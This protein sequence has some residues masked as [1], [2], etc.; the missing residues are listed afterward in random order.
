MKTRKSNWTAPIIGILFLLIL[1]TGC[2][3][4]NEETLAPEIPVYA[5]SFDLSDIQLRE[6]PFLEARETN[7]GYLLSLEPDRFLA[8]FRKEAGLEPKGEVYGG[9]ESEGYVIAG[10]SLGHYLSALSKQYHATGDERFKERVDYIVK[11][12]ALVQEEHGDGYVAAIRDG[13][14]AFKEI[15]EGNI[16][17]DGFSLNEVNVPWY[18]LDKTFNGLRDAF[19]LAENEQALEVVT[20]LTTWAYNITEDLTE[21]EWQEMLS[22]EFGGMIHSLANVYAIT[23]NPRHLKLAEKFYHHEVLDP[24]SNGKDELEGLHA[25][26]QIPKV[27]GVA[28]IHELTDKQ[29]YHTIA[30][31]FWNQVVSSHTYVNGGHGHEEAFGPPN[32]LSERLNH[33]TETC[34]TYNMLWLTRMLFSWNPDGELMDYYE[35]AL[36]NHIL[37]S[38]NPETG[39]FVYKG[40][41]DMPTRKG[42]SDSTNSF[43]CCVGTGMEN[44]THY[45]RD[46]Y[47][48]SG[49][50]LYVNLFMA[51]DLEWE[52]Q[53]LVLKQETDFPVEEGSQ[54]TLSTD[55]PVE[56]SLLIREPNWWGEDMEFTVNGDR[57]QLTEPEDGYHEIRRT[58][59]DGDVIEI[60][61]PMEHRIEAMPDDEK[62][63]AF[64]YGPVLL[65]AILEEEPADDGE[66]GE[67]EEENTKVPQLKGSKEELLNA[68]EP[69]EGKELHFRAEGVGR[70]KN[71]DTGQWETTDIYLKPQYQTV[72]ELYTVYMDIQ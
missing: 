51:S 16:Q 28:K 38:Q 58:F 55:Q 35:R 29:D 14:E 62:R 43:W 61:M 60:N 39:M 21:E 53:G 26:T 63:I 40:Y 68:L 27:R 3:R 22:V 57:K 72:N 59:K 24:L 18:N 54:L 31:F 32:Q 50:S 33:T 70:M 69:V 47:Y 36:Y 20:K 48:R 44:H 9:W 37:A 67:D 42:F 2:Q 6:S 13:R 56:L 45:G 65:N 1:A 10:H 66:E 49:D 30:D 64:F 4:T 71:E 23:G 17:P 19:L 34:N 8:W 5:E 46:V 52:E 12:L 25:N 11:E 15:S 7:A 41:L